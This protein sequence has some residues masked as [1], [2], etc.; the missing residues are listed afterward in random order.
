MA[1]QNY[2]D[3][4]WTTVCD[5][6]FIIALRE[7]LDAADIFQNHGIEPVPNDIELD[8][9]S[10][11]LL[12]ARGQPLRLLTVLLDE[13]GPENAAIATTKFL[14]RV[15]PKLLVLVG[16]SGRIS[17]D[18]RLGD[19]VLAT[20][21]DN[22]Y[23]RA[24]K[25]SNET[26]P[27]GREWP[28]DALASRLA[29]AIAAAP[30]YYSYSGLNEA[31]IENLRKAGL[32]GESPR[33]LHGAIATTP[34]LIDDP[35]FANWLQTSRNRNV[36]ATDMESAAVVQAA[37]ASGI[38][39][40]RVLVVRG[41]SDLA[42]GTKSSA[43]A[44]GRGAIRKLAM[45]NASQLA[46]HCIS[47]LITF[48]EDGIRVKTTGGDR[49]DDI[50]S[51]YADTL[52]ELRELA[53]QVD[54]SGKNEQHACLDIASV[55]RK[56]SLIA[57]QLSDLANAAYLQEIERK[58]DK[59]QALLQRLPR[60]SIDFLI[61]KWIMDSLARDEPTPQAIEILSKV[62]PQRINRFCKAFM[63]VLRDERVL[64]DSLI[65]AYG[66][67]IKGPN[68][69]RSHERA[70]A[71]IC[72]L[73]GRLR[74]SQQRVRAA[75][76][77][78]GWRKKLFPSHLDSKQD[79]TQ[80]IQLERAFA[81]IDSPERRLLVRT[82]CISLVL[83]GQKGES[84]RYVRACLRSKEFD[85]LNRGFHLEYYGDIDYDPGQ[86]MNN[87][88]PVTAQW[89]RTFETLLGKLT[90]SF[91]LLQPYALRDVELQTL[92]SL[93]QHRHAAQSLE[94]GQR[95]RLVKFLTDWPPERLTSIRLLEAFAEM[96]L[97]SLKVERM[98]RADLIRKLYELKKLPRSGW[99]DRNARHTRQNPN[100]ESV[101]S[102]TA[103]GLILLHFCLP[104]RV[105]K[106]D[107]Q[108]LGEEYSRSY[109]KD[110]IARI[111]LTH[112][113]AEAYTGD[114]LPSQR[115]DETKAEEQRVNSRIDLFSTWPGFYYF[116]MYRAWSDF[117]NT[118]TINGRI[119]KEID[120]L[121]NLL[122]LTIEIDSP[123]VT[124]SDA[125][126]WRDDVVRRISTPM[127]R[128]ILEMLLE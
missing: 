12:D 123:N 5:V 62:Y 106:E 8:I 76:V 40:G 21:C 56:N 108:Q 81:I 93:A 105:S 114:L 55:Q 78:E 101:L 43:D 87:T 107:R 15:E 100:P 71:H 109:S 96:L 17:H 89:T 29:P 73:M 19:V 94:A 125:V 61:A 58:G 22:S 49:E 110:E 113:L 57:R 90:L 11:Q 68:A 122:Q 31:T 50:I 91:S 85:S 117:E 23:Y 32:L 77:L 28:L 59:H 41:I 14:Q 75:E 46:S 7:E 33:T 13:Q 120:A 64:V 83:L 80:P 82:I 84:E 67:K 24:K 16:I 1:T 47:R 111:F 92:L 126:A 36:L 102:H 20:L 98:R 53:E 88:D 97:D 35:E 6:A 86:S 10:R 127:G 128:R 34:F 18:C 65:R 104:E 115:N 74:N 27:G 48:D 45:Q 44:L 39:N 95:L 52:Q 37:H 119:A 60:T 72:Y 69:S 99:N 70:K 116:G 112:D 9:H 63:S 66:S 118:G 4:R 124:V 38:R 121:E 103:G 54:H 30:A 51:P 3:G 26:L 79:P 42:D 2:T 25:K